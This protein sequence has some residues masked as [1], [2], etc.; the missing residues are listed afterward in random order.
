MIIHTGGCACSAVRFEASDEPLRVGLCHCMICR[1][2][3]AS[4][5][6]PFVVY[7]AEKVL[8]AGSLR[9]W[10]S[11]DHATRL[12][13]E[14]C[15][16]PICQQEDEGGEIE[17]HLGSFDEPSLFAPMYENWIMHR[18]EWLPH[19]GIPERQTDLGYR[20]RPTQKH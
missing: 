13:C 9:A 16:S 2:H 20:A 11:S 10:R 12:S 6:N 15:S 17:L 18:E 8:I 1:K 7:K 19:L 3:H 14:V 5:F 4:A